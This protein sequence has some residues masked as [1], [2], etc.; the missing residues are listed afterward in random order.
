MSGIGRGT[1]KSGVIRSSTPMKS[2]TPSS[3]SSLPLLGSTLLQAALNAPP[4][5]IIQPKD[6][7]GSDVVSLVERALKAWTEEFTLVRI[8]QRKG[9]AMHGCADEY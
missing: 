3:A 8:Y 4:P 5:K 6:D 1:P 9:M 7:D 2:S